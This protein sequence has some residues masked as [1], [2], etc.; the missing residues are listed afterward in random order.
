M[1]FSAQKMHFFDK[2][3]NLAPWPTRARADVKE[4]FFPLIFFYLNSEGFVGGRWRR[5]WNPPM[6]IFNS[7]KKGSFLEDMKKKVAKSYWNPIHRVSVTQIHHDTMFLIQF[8]VKMPQF[9]LKTVIY[10]IFK[11]PH[12]WL[13]SGVPE[14]K[15]KFRDKFYNIIDYNKC[16]SSEK[17]DEKGIFRKS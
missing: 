12:F 13:F 1:L 7:A 15:L 14:V 2:N 5:W 3:G 16:P 9:L 6:N 4:L 10:I 17:E 11:N 8:F